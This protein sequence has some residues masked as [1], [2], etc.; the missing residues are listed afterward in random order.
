MALLRYNQ[1][2]RPYQWSDLSQGLTKT[3]DNKK[4]RLNSFSNGC[5]LPKNSD[6]TLSL[7][8]S[9][10]E[11]LAPDQ[12]SLKAAGKLLKPT[13]W[14]LLATDSDYIWGECQGSGANPY[15]VIFDLRDHGY[16]CTC[17]SRKFPCK[18]ALALALMYS[19][20]PSDFVQG[21]LP[22]WGTDW[23]GR[24]R[25][26][27]ATSGAND[28]A[29][30]RPAKSLAAALADEPKTPA[31]PKKAAALEAARKTRAEATKAAQMAGL[32]ELEDWLS[33][34][35]TLGLPQVLSDL[36]TR[37]RTISARL[38]DA[39]APAL[40][41]RLDDIPERVMSASRSAR[42]DALI[43]ELGKL[44]LLSRAAQTEPPPIGL[45]RLISSA[46]TRDA[47]LDDPAAQTHRAV[48]RVIAMHTR[49]RKDGLVS[50][51]TW[52]LS[53]DE[54]P[55]FAQL[56]DF[57]PASL[58]KRGAGFTVGDV[59]E[60]EVCYFPSCAPLRAVIKD[61]IPVSEDADWTG[62]PTLVSEQLSAFLGAEPWMQDIPIL[63]QTGRLA[64]ARDGSPVWVGQS[65]EMYPLHQSAVPPV[66]FG[67]NLQSTAA[68]MRYGR[69]F[70]L[71]SKTEMGVIYYDE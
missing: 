17:P 67:L 15:R 48:W 12:A 59:F 21:Q 22:E 55:R 25:K 20:A 43:E 40:S 36:T 26:Q 69:L 5:L 30:S 42:T 61:R 66:A 64:V 14:P 58:G 38:S 52:L 53:A 10:I 60:A 3:H 41:G 37:C 44:V 70:L 7:A 13:K 11:N 39:K 57:V 49:T 62:S 68:L 35:L 51:A 31:D 6:T 54:R 46:E 23:I 1:I 28:D 18:H 45:Q 33:D 47:L 56:L 34:N 24:R 65:Q 19:D 4:L 27:T 9:T 16:K 32:T 8:A 63:L 2:V 29:T 71:A 50:Y